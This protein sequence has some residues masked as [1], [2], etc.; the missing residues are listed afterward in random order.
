MKTGARA[1]LEASKKLN[2]LFYGDCLTVMQDFGRASVDLIYL[3]PPFRSNGQYNGIYKDET[4][5]PLPYQIQAFC[6]VWELDAERWR[7]IRT[8]PVLM[9]ENGIDEATV[10]LWRLWMHALQHTRP[11][12][13]AYLSYMAERLLVMHRILKPTGS[14][15]F[16]CDPTI[17]HYVKLIL[18]AVFGH[19]QFRSE[20]VWKRS[21]RKSAAFRWSDTTDRLLFYTKSERYTWNQQY[22]PHNPEYVANAYRYDDG[23]GLGKY[24]RTPLHAVGVRAGDSGSAWRGYAPSLHNRHWAMPTRESM[25]R[26]IVESGL[27]PDWPHAYASVQERLD[28]LDRAGLIVHSDTYLPEIKTYFEATNGIAITDLITDIPRASGNERMGYAIQKPAGL[29]ERIIESSTLPGDVVLDPFCGCATTLEAA[30]NLGRKWMGIDIA[31]HA[32]KRV[33]RV[34]LEERLGL[35]EGQDFA[36]EGIPKTVGGAQNLWQRDKYQFQKWA[37]E[38]VEGFVTTKRAVD[39]GVDGRLYFA[40]PNSQDLQCMAIS[41]KG[42]NPSIRDL[43]VLKGVL[44]NDS[45]LMAGMIVMK[46]PGRTKV[47]DFNRFIAVAGTLEILGKVYP[48]VQLLDVE[49]ILEGERFM[50]PTVAG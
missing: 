27:I 36:V 40:I 17:S 15:Y 24:K 3:D 23:D 41:V 32:I 7:S 10:E 8:M 48:R 26:F 38:Q 37:V 21:R 45:A 5:W 20:I 2:H 19:N 11:R 50:T 49:Q 22:E 25:Q 6:D 42:A 29:V 18:D 1:G 16:H 33:A 12:L 13:L 46:L 4:G 14:L 34:R 30:H 28:A 47:R 31:I 39:G 43:R 9:R 44:E 35:V